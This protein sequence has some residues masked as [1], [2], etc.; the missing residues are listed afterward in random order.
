[1]AGIES[2]A[3][4][5]GG[6]H[7]WVTQG[8]QVGAFFGGLNTRYPRDRQ[9]IAF[10]MCTLL[11]QRHGSRLHGH[12]RRSHRYAFGDRLAADIDHSGSTVIVEMREPTHN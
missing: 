4:V 10:L 11:Q 9:H 12:D 5:Y 3:D 1:L 6:Q 8:N 2:K 7:K